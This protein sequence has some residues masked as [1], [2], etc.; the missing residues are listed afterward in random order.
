MPCYR[1]WAC[2]WLLKL[3][4][5]KIASQHGLQPARNVAEGG[6]GRQTLGRHVSG[7]AVLEKGGVL[8][9]NGRAPAR[10]TKGA[11]DATAAAVL[12]LRRYW[13]FS[14]SCPGNR[15]FCG[16]AADPN[17]GRCSI[18]PIYLYPNHDEHH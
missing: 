2:A 17:V 6:V 7:K 18:K 11:A 5:F 13:L 1:V 15:W 3:N 8:A 12:G 14:R 10:P 9:G 16:G 4:P